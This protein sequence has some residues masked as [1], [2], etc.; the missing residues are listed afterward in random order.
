MV[1]I[2]D[3]GGWFGLKSRILKVDGGNL[4][5]QV[6]GSLHSSVS[7]DWLCCFF[8]SYSQVKRLFFFLVFIILVCVCDSLIVLFL[9]IFDA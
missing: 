2:L 3:L 8:P 7:M 6:G 5:E 9:F 1:Q 4:T